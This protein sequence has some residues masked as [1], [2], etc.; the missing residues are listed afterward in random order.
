MAQ[1]GSR[2]ERMGR[3]ARAERFELAKFERGELEEVFEEALP[4]AEAPRESAGVD[5][6]GAAQAF[7]T[8][9][10]PELK[11]AIAA[12]SPAAIERAYA[13]AAARR[14][15]RLH[16]PR[17]APRLGRGRG[18]RTLRA[19]PRG[20]RAPLGRQAG[21]GAP[22][23]SRGSAAPPPRARSSTASMRLPSP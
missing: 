3:A 21:R 14:R 19:A 23:S 17:R 11:A 15:R 6:A 12:K 2:F 9:D 13:S 8:T 16:P 22:R 1:V 4:R 5:L 18:V 10:L 7:T 20:R